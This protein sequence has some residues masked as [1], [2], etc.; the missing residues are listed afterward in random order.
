MKRVGNYRAPRTAWKPGQS[1]NPKGRPP[2]GQTYRELAANRPESRKQAVI[3]AMEEAA[4][5]DKRV[6]AAEFLRDT[7][8]G[9][10]RQT[11]ELDTGPGDERRVELLQRLMLM[12]SAG[13][14]TEAETESML[15]E[16]GW[17][18]NWE[19]PGLN[20]TKI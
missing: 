4:I 9:K 12:Q 15:T 10:P 6:A 1:G 16:A 14:L 3:E 5:L 8:E 19:Q 20:P 17:L 7:A 18:K 2:K 13:M 11:V